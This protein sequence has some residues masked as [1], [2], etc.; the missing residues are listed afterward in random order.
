MYHRILTWNNEAALSIHWEVK[1]QSKERL[2]Q[3][4]ANNTLFSSYAHGAVSEIFNSRQI[5][6]LQSRLDLCDWLAIGPLTLLAYCRPDRG[7]LTQHSPL[8]VHSLPTRC[9]YRA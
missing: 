1:A 6:L 2:A 4:T 7:E 8:L 5:V 3:I 9:K